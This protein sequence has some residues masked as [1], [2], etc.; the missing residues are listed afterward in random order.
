LRLQTPPNPTIHL[1]SVTQ[2]KQSE[3]TIIRVASATEMATVENQ[4]SEIQTLSNVKIP[5]NF[6][7]QIVQAPKIVEPNELKK[8]KTLIKLLRSD[9]L[10]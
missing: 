5:Y 6:G 9:D 2:I 7:N 10:F 4:Q 8:L 3:D 1:A